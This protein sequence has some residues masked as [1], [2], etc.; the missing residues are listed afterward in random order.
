MSFADD[1]I[2]GER[3]HTSDVRISHF[4]DDA[5]IAGNE[6]KFNYQGDGLG[7]YDIYQF[8]RSESAAKGDYVRVGEYT[9]D[10]ASSTQLTLND[11]A[12]NWGGAARK[13]APLSYCNEPCGIGQI[14]RFTSVEKCCWICDK[15]GIYGM[16]NYSSK[17]FKRRYL[18][19]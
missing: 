19:F 2:A 11:S 13:R 14:T 9:D 7:L 1:F 15:C 18:C 12:L 5:G 6:V 16:K 3:E 10:G 17:K 8:Q 4:S